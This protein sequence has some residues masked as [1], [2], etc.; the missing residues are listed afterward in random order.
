VFSGKSL[1][2]IHMARMS[3]EDDLLV[4]EAVVFH[5]VRRVAAFRGQTTLLPD[6]YRVGREAMIADHRR[7]WKHTSTL[8]RL[9]PTLH[10]LLN[11]AQ[12][13]WTLVLRWADLEEP[14][15]LRERRKR[16]RP[17]LKAI[18]DF[19]EETSVVPRHKWL[20]SYAKDKQFSLGRRPL[21]PQEQIVEQAR[22]LARE[23]GLEMPPFDPNAT[24]PLWT[25]DDG[26]RAGE[27]M[28][29]KRMTNV[30]A[31][32][33]LREFLEHCSSQS[34]KRH[35]A[36]NYYRALQQDKKG[37]FRHWPAASQ[38][39]RRGPWREQLD[40]AVHPD[41]LER[42]AAEDLALL[43]VQRQRA[44]EPQK[45]RPDSPRALKVLELLREQSPRTRAQLQER[46]GG[47]KT[48]L[49]RDLRAL[50]DAGLILKVAGG[51]SSAYVICD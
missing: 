32:V 45:G 35:P 38:L 47:T 30:S 42:A 24:R 48:P 31:I 7:K 37:R 3:A 44:A 34:P 27:A 46:V 15:K 11:A 20:E 5:A 51:R 6:E 39:Q 43:Q 18:I 4:D 19:W 29:Q 2:R 25:T 49:N 26:R 17:Y 1:E 14:P 22:E 10:Q 21:G 50:V 23:R 33:G 8:E 16:S 40:A 28:P 41:A 12:G 13:D 9:L 36:L